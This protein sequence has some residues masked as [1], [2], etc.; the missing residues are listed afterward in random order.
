VAMPMHGHGHGKG[1]G[2]HRGGPRGE[3]H[4][5]M[6]GGHPGM[7][8][9]GQAAPLRRPAPESVSVV[10]HPGC[11]AGTP[12]SSA[13]LVP[14]FFMPAVLTRKPQARHM[15]HMAACAA[16]AAHSGFFRAA[17][18]H[19]AKNSFHLPAPGTDPLRT[20]LPPPR[21]HPLGGSDAPPGR[22]GQLCHGDAA[23]GSVSGILPG[24][25]LYK[26]TT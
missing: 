19:S 12:P 5:G 4:P 7:G 22:S 11:P 9:P 18:P 14:A 15:C 24:Q 16:H 8:Q 13:G 10:R 1:P 3:G 6:R 20:R 23:A 17:P 25:I 21:V 26:T 2:M